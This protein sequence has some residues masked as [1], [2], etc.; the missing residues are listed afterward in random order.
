MK[1]KI[2]QYIKDNDYSSKGL[3]DAIKGSNWLASDTNYTSGIIR[4]SEGEFYF[5]II[6]P[7]AFCLNGK[8][9]VERM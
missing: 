6:K 8:I 4:T 2:E 1:K 3:C 9:T 5:S 7:W